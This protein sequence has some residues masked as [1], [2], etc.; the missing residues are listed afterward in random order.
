MQPPVAQEN[1]LV[2][3]FYIAQINIVYLA[4]LKASLGACFI[5]SSCEAQGDVH[6]GMPLRLFQH[7]HL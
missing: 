3:V 2:R 5:V 1:I 4:R 7:Y 6:Y